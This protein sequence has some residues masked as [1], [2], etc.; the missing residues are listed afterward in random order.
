MLF[1]KN[2]TVYG[3]ELLPRPSSILIERGRFTRVGPSADLQAPAGATVIDAA[4]FSVVPG[5]ID[6]QFNGGFGH[7]FTNDAGPIWDVAARL[8]QFGVTS[9]L[10]TIITSPLERITAGQRVV[11]AG[12]PEGFTGAMPLGLHIEGPYLNAAKKGAHNPKY[13]RMPD[14]R[15][16][17]DWSPSTGVRLVTI[18]PELPGAL[19]VITDLSRRG[20]LVSAGHS[21]ATYEEAMAAFD[22]GVRYGTHLFSAMPSLLH[23]E[24]GLPG[25]MLTDSRPLVG[26]IADGVHT[27]QCIIDLVWKALGSARLSLVTDAMAALGMPPGWHRLGDYDVQVD[28]TSARLD[29][30]TLA[31]SILSLDRAL[32][33][34]IRIT[35][36]SLEAVLPTLTTNN[37][38]AIGLGH[39]RGRIAAGFVADLVMLSPDLDVYSTVAGGK[40]AYTAGA[41]G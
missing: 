7:D 26:F 25:A 34:V 20:V 13:L 37:A 1:I 23:R 8:P 17:A 40:V 10:P 6:L 36:C 28:A 24:P 15:E 32:R 35:G 41:R 5:F 18:A 11:A 33:N 21:M 14:R 30:R 9:F 4:G 2:A 3:P 16:V 19:D 38:K 12:P 31:G 22:A 27:H 29:A 39:E